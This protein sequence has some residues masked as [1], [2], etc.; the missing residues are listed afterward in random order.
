MFYDTCWLQHYLQEMER[1]D[2]V[3]SCDDFA[4][5]FFL[6]V[7]YITPYSSLWNVTDIPSHCLLTIFM[8][9]SLF[10]CY[11]VYISCSRCCDWQSPRCR[12]KL[13]QQPLQ[14]H[15]FLREPLQEELFPALLLQEGHPSAGRLQAQDRDLCCG[16]QAHP[17]EKSKGDKP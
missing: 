14:P 17:Q 11:F 9:I 8:F 4:S 1:I 10:F 7:F 13:P 16:T 6:T 3:P 12:P 5:W 2:T 15:P